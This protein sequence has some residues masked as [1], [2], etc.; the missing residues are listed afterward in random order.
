MGNRKTRIRI[1]VLAILVVMV[2][3][4]VL[5]IELRREIPRAWYGDVVAAAQKC[6][7]DRCAQFVMALDDGFVNHYEYTL[8]TLLRKSPVPVGER[9]KWALLALVAKDAR[10]RG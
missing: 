5:D 9:P 8:L 4:L 1:I 7:G 6:S 10:F 3:A 2:G